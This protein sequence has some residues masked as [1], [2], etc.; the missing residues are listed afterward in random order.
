LFR[1]LLFCLLANIRTLEMVEKK[2]GS[3]V[4]LNRIST[5]PIP[6]G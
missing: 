4:I 2:V 6:S 3:K 1:L 5:E